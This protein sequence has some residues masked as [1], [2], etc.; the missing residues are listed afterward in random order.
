MCEK[1]IEETEKPFILWIGF[2]LHKTIAF[3]EGWLAPRYLIIDFLH[4]IVLLL[5]TAQSK[6]RKP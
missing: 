6:Y 3:S 2:F 4:L 5:L 1:Q